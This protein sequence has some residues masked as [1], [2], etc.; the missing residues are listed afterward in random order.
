LTSGDQYVSEKIA[1]D[2]MLRVIPSLFK[3][4]ETTREWMTGTFISVVAS[5]FFWLY[6]AR[7]R[8]YLTP[9]LTIASAYVMSNPVVEIKNSDN[10]KSIGTFASSNPSATL[11]IVMTICTMITNVAGGSDVKGAFKD[12]MG[13]MAVSLNDEV[14][15]RRKE[16]RYRQMQKAQIEASA[17]FVALD[18]IGNTVTPLA[19]DYFTGLGGYAGSAAINGAKKFIGWRD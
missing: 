15:W 8:F 19:V 1:S 14:D 18:Y 5:V 3:I 4:N 10:L 13:T 9:L 16:Q 17:P 6:G 2:A 7:K 12:A 11:M